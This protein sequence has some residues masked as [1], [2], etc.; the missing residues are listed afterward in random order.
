[1][2]SVDWHTA[3]QHGVIVEMESTKV[4]RKRDRGETKVS[5]PWHFSTFQIYINDHIPNISWLKVVVFWASSILVPLISTTL[6]LGPIEALESTNIDH[7]VL[8]VS[9]V[10]ATRNPFVPNYLCSHFIEVS[11]MTDWGLDT[12]DIAFFWLRIPNLWQLVWEIQKSII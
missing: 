10:N 5:I 8:P 11:S 3:S 12:S 2:R 6:T 4:S 9:S 1:M 7:T